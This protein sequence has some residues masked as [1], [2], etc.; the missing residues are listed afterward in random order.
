[1]VEYQVNEEIGIAN[2]DPEFF[3]YEY[4][5]TAELEDEVFKVFIFCFQQYLFG[6]DFGLV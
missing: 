1:M 3:A 5:I 6:V 2:L 4:K